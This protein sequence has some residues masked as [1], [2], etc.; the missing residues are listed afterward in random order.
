MD[1]LNKKNEY[2]V[3]LTNIVC[4]LL[5][6]G[7]LSMYIDGTKLCNT[8]NIL[9]VFQSILKN[10]PEWD[11]NILSTETT[12]I[13]TSTRFSNLEKLLKV[14]LKLQVQCFTNNKILIE[15]QMDISFEKFIHTCYITIS[16]ELYQYPELLYLENKDS[17]EKRNNIVKINTI[18]KHGIE[19]SIKKLLPLDILLDEE[20]TKFD[21][22]NDS[23]VTNL[24]TL[25]PNNLPNTNQSDGM[26]RNDLVIQGGYRSSRSS[27]HKISNNSNK[28]SISNN[29]DRHSISNN[30]D[31]H[32][33]SNNSDKHSISN[34]SDK[35]SISNKPQ[36]INDNIL[37][38]AYTNVSNS[39]NTNAIINKMQKDK[40]VLSS[41]KSQL[42]SLK[43][44][45]VNTIMAD[46]SISYNIENDDKYVSVFNNN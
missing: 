42:K 3:F 5:Y 41:D 45:S 6:D 15:K 25:K 11:S 31:R 9:L 24:N 26:I 14:I 36:L 34:N 8:D 20:L 44:S 35:H 29:S 16:K 13:L 37:E 38:S 18:I 4:P 40:T 30:S 2:I 39:T 43:S 21:N 27:S 23:L 10:I 12:R 32:S 19:Y 1:N 17:I 33:I 28:H 7:F 22:N 46:T